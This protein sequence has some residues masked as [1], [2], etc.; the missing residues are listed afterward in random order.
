[1]AREENRYQPLGQIVDKMVR[2]YVR[3]R[4]EIDSEDQNN[5]HYKEYHAYV[6]L[7]DR[8]FRGDRQPDYR[9]LFDGIDKLLTSEERTA[10]RKSLMP[11]NCD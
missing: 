5:Q 8:S 10:L 1:M 4:E 6:E 2:L 3:H 11:D 9:K 7:L